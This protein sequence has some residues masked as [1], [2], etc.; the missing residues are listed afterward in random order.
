ME[1]YGAEVVA[2]PSPTTNY[3][4]SVL[5]ETPGQPGLAGHRHQRGGRGRGDP[6]RH[7]VRPR[8]GAQPRAPAPDG[9]R[10]GGH[11]A[12]GHGRRVAGRRHRLH[13]R[14]LELRRADLPVPGPEL[15]RRREAPDH[16]RRAGGGPE[17]DPRRVR[18]RLRGHRQDGAAGQDAHARRRLHARADPRRRPALPRHGAA[19]QPAQGARLHRGAQRPP[20]LELRGRASRSPGPRASCRRPSRP[21][22]SGSPSTRPSPRGRR[23]R[24]G[25]SCSTCAATVTS[26]CPPTSATCPGELEDY[27]YPAEK[28]E[29]ALAA[30]PAVGAGRLTPGTDPRTSDGSSPGGRRDDPSPMRSRAWRDRDDR[31]GGRV[32]PMMTRTAAGRASCI[33]RIR[34]RI[35]C[36]Q[37]DAVRPSCRTSGCPCRDWPAGPAGARSTPSSPLESLVRRGAALSAL[38]GVPGPRAPRDRAPRA[39][40]VGRTRPTIPGRPSGRRRA[41]G[42]RPP[43]RHAPAGATGVS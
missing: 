25:S 16:R 38:R 40:T 10:P 19:G 33:C 1:T 9:H 30:L 43:A 18:L 4:R 27:E 13:R 8:L 21:T 26:T 39:R 12:D 42:G 6:R 36:V 23:A 2:S 11:R 28:V 15:P 24:R 20:A 41:P 32:L 37:R 5:A 34:A 31:R 35:R 3:G 14:R 17:P 22:P 7:E 29:A